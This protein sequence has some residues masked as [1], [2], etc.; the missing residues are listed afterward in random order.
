[1]NY[2]ELEICFP[3]WRGQAKAISS[4]Q[5]ESRHQS[6]HCTQQETS[7]RTA[8]QFTN[9]VAQDGLSEE[10]R[11]TD[12]LV[13]DGVL[14]GTVYHSKIQRN[15]PIISYYYLLSNWYIWFIFR[16][17]SQTPSIHMKY[18]NFCST[19]QYE[20]T[21]KQIPK[22]SRFPQRSSFFP[23][24]PFP[25]TWRFQR[26]SCPMASPSA[27]PG[28]VAPTSSCAAA[29][30]CSATQSFCRRLQEVEFEVK[31]RQRVGMF[32]VGFVGIYIGGL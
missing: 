17:L 20:T 8:A 22:T 30:C 15:E 21:H 6:E 13:R 1:M 10:W 29:T 28:C 24:H 19:I 9:R 3:L 4:S 5:S 27:S 23:P 16:W 7:K 25:T 31:Y 26:S 14:W 18:P 11:E 2:N 12:G 32:G